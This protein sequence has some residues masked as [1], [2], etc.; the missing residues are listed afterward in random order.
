[1]ANTTAKQ[2]KDK[3]AKRL[4]PERSKEYKGKMIQRIQKQTDI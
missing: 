2:H 3:E 1:M 4:V